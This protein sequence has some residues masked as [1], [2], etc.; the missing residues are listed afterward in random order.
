MILLRASARHLARHPGFGLAA[1][2]KKK[3]IMLR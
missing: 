2:S 1:K 3:Y